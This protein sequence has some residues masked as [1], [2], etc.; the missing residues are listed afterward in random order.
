V[1]ENFRRDFLDPITG[2]GLAWQAKNRY[3]SQDETEGGIVEVMRFH[4]YERER[5]AL[6]RHLPLCQDPTRVAPKERLTACAFLQ[7]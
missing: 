5:Q 3:L 2:G 1:G 7:S 6:Q 4:Q